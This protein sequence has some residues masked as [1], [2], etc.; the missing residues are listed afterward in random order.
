M[1]VR[2]FEARRA[3][4]LKAAR[5]ITD[6][7][8]KEDR[9]MTAEESTAFEAHLAS[10]SALKSQIEGL[11]ALEL[12][13]AGLNA[14]RTVDIG[15]ARVIETKD[16]QAADP[17]RGFRTL[18][19]FCSVVYTSSGRNAA[20][21]K[22][23]SM[24]ASAPGTAGGE[25]NGTD[26]GFLVPPEFSKQIFQLSLEEDSLLPL[27]DNVPVGGNSMVF[28]K[29]ETTPWGSDGVRAYW[30]SEA[31]SATTTKPKFGI[32]T[33][34]LH[35]LMALVP[36]TDELLADT[37]ALNGY[38]PALFGRSIRWKTDEA[39]LFGSGAGQP[40][41][42]FTKAGSAGFP[43]VV[44]AEESG[45][46]AGS[47]VLNNVTN[48]IARLPPGSFA[49]ATWKITPDLL[50]QVFGMTLGNYPIY[51][52]LNSGAAGS[53]YVGT[54]MGRPLAVSQHC[55]ARGQQGD[56]MLSDMSYYRSL[57]KAGG[58]ETA[59]SM[60]LYFDAD[61]T[62]FRATFRVDGAPKLANP[63]AQA[64]GANTLSPFITLGAR[65]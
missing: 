21:D 62:A 24:E 35:K 32:S 4:A 17:K 46:A 42:A 38:L 54:L 2:K 50:P 65:P 44:Q 23:L 15:A 63:I 29:D 34:R 47:L 64:K 8:A 11:K 36:L 12:E 53:P 10:A 61:A 40:L 3:A 45:Q 1:S 55:A 26:G 28:P 43:A 52:P 33:M 14:D 18:G 48:M 41:G 19:E 22:R 5:E 56:L 20:V 16:N 7:V 57:T 25:G 39:L 58:I 37:D 27:T 6:L 13:E 60:H 51:L 31:T 30:Q 59:S 49:K 9:D